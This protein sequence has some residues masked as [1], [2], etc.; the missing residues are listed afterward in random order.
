MCGIAGFIGLGSLGDLQAMTGAMAHRGPDAS[1]NIEISGP[2]LFLGHRRLSIVDLAA[3]A[4]PLWDAEKSGCISY[5]GEV[6]NHLDLRRELE[7]RGRRFLTRTDTEV[8]LNACLEWGEQAL[9]K[10]NG[11]FAFAV[12]D[13]R[14]G[15]LLLARDRFGKKPLY[16]A[17]HAGGFLFASELT[18]LLKHPNCPRDLDTQAVPR[19]FAF[20]SIPAPD[21]IL[22]GVRKLEPGHLL[23]LNLSSAA[24]AAPQRWYAFRIAPDSGLSLE[25]AARRFHELFKAA[26]LR[27]LM[28]DVPLGVFLSGGM[29]SAAVAQMLAENGVRPTCYSIGFEERSFDESA[30]AAETARHF[31]FTHRL[32][33]FTAAEV[34]ASIARALGSLD[35][36]MGDASIVPTFL[37]CEFARSEVTVALGGD[38]SDEMLA[39][40]DPFAALPLFQK[41]AGLGGL[42]SGLLAPILK[43]AARCLPTRHGNMTLEFRLRRMLRAFEHA[44]AN[45]MPAWLAALGTREHRDIFPQAPA[46]AAILAERSLRAYSSP[47]PEKLA[48]ESIGYYLDTYLP[49]SVLCKVDRASMR[50]SLEVRAPFLDA[51]LAGLFAALPWDLRFRFPKGK[52]L[53]RRHLAGKVPEG[54]LRRPKKGF[55]M[56]VARWLAGPLRA[57]M[58]DALRGDRLADLGL[59]PAATQRIW[60]EHLEKRADQRAFLWDLMVLAD[61]KE[62]V[63]RP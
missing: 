46:L 37:L 20:N 51:E 44:P 4:Q 63:L 62:R 38:G 61:W 28:S 22:R 14:A 13:A 39:G 52:V 3:P 19:Y 5:N 2:R 18:A 60:R 50:V 6:Y 47:H 25:E 30:A 21:T 40:Y 12:Y 55:G 45:W 23:S 33:M 16:Y 57:R 11:M 41:T 17:A 26:V 15:R 54:V 53:L 32:K 29:D 10:L 56:P 8:V 59:D 1:G 36:P 35:E 48:E 9:P 24:A 43:A 7:A 31:G 49:D 58:E 34:E 27:R 42:G